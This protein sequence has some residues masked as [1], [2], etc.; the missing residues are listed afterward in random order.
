[1]VNNRNEYFP[2]SVSPPGE[3]L[4]EL[5]E[6]MKMPQAE[7][8][9][10]MGR[11][12]KTINEIIKG[13]V[14]ITPETALQ[15]ELVLDIPA[16][17]WNNREKRYQEYLA[18]ESEKKNL[19]D[20]ILWIEHFPTREMIKLEWLEKYNNK[21]DL[22]RE[23]LNFFG[24]ASP[25][26]WETIWLKSADAVFRQSPVFEADQYCVS[27]WLRKGEI[28][29]QRIECNAY[30]SKAFY[31]AL[32]KIRSL[33]EDSPREFVPKSQELCA[34]AG[35]ALV[36]IPSLP[37]TRASGATRWLS[38]NKAMI[39][40]SLRYKTNDHLWFTFF[41][42]AGHILLHGKREAFVED[43]SMN[44]KKENEAN[45]FAADFL[46]PS[47]EYSAFKPTYSHYSKEDVI[48]FARTI[49]IDPGIVVGRLQHDGKIAQQNMN[50]LKKHLT[51]VN[52]NKD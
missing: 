20:Q 19:K 45:K 47:D 27:V 38:K 36:F 48:N 12:I 22:L 51:W 44:T 18:R 31:R 21:I 24:I 6:G 35:V 42:E 34:Q 7:L 46:I 3:T 30:D 15:L 29:A 13:K 52:E 49:E 26:D 5:L 8:A 4:V 11:P 41:H 39:Q 16:S 32:K 25:K 40:L 33:T 14:A 28:D 2:D 10:R 50:D 9:R 43:G 23:L 17:F 1:M 37:K